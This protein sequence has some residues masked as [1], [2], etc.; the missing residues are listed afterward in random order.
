MAEE[1]HMWRKTLACERLEKEARVPSTSAQRVL[2][3]GLLICQFFAASPSRALDEA[4]YAELLTRF[5]QVVS[6]T[7]GTRVDYAGLRVSPDWP[8]LVKSVEQTELSGLRTR[9]ERLAFWIN[10]YNI[11]T[12]DILVKNKPVD[13]ILYLGSVLR[14]VWKKSAG[15]IGDRSY[16][17][18]EIEHRILR[19]MGEPRIHAAIVCASTSCPSLLREPWLARRI[20]EQLDAAVTLWLK[21]NRKGLRIDREARV[22]HVSKI[23]SWFDEDF[24]A[25]GGVIEFIR[26]YVSG[27]D[28]VWLKVNAANASLEYLDYDWSLN[29][30]REPAASRN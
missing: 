26:P 28:R 9:A 30:I 16:S 4:L 24:E 12:V 13:S 15:R 19:P 18:D 22:I 8:R 29:R 2:T 14:P 10:V 21:E 20:D 7:A 17:L 23:F 3:A 6:D 27:L 25:G 1:I 5:T 11:F